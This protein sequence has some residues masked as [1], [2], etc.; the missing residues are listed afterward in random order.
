MK[1]KFKFIYIIFFF[2]LFNSFFFGQNKL[3]LDQCINLAFNNNEQ[4]KI[5]NIESKYYKES[6]I[7]SYEIP[8]TSFI[9]TQGQFNSIYNLDNNIT[10]SQTIPF[11]TLL[12]AHSKL[13]KSYITGAEIKISSVKADIG[14]QIKDLYYNL[15]HS[16]QE[17]I[18]LQKED[19]IYDLFLKL[20]DSRN[21]LSKKS[22]LEK[23]TTISES[24]LIKSLISNAQ[25][26]INTFKIKLK[27]MM[28]TKELPDIYILSDDSRLLKLDTNLFI[29]SSHPFLLYLKEQI[30]LC[31]Q[32]KNVEVQKWFP[33]IMFSYFN[34][35]I[36]GPAN[37]YGTDYFLT[38]ANRLQGFQVGFN[39]PLFFKPHL[40][41]VKA[42][43]LSIEVATEEYHK[44]LK[45]MEGNYK[46]LVNEYIMTN[47]NIDYYSKNI[48]KNAKE[49][50]FQSLEAYNNK[51]INYI[52][53]LSIISK[54][55]EIERNYLNLILENN[56]SVLKLE[57][58]LNK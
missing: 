14:L 42:A 4:L 39:I 7:A 53:Y 25:M 56:Q 9:Y 40:S 17:I 49:M 18:L 46:V 6:K 21:E 35:S 33:D 12:M 34:Q 16:L 28:R 47:K 15:Q 48:L 54:S 13:A 2:Y 3:T 19:S 43:G 29:S 32:K 31:V 11:P 27:T 51:E 10:V 58:F 52:E 36:Y 8:K 57:Y 20:E 22:T 44:N 23:S 30:N 5:A 41:K 50:S 37:I 1:V 55:F 26:Q 38:R 45:D 24:Y